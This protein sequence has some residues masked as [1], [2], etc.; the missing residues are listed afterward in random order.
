M[1]YGKKVL[2]LL[3]FDLKW[4]WLLKWICCLS[5]MPTHPGSWLEVSQLL[6][7]SPEPILLLLGGWLPSLDTSSMTSSWE[8]KSAWIKIYR[9][10]HSYR[11]AHCDPRCPQH[12]R[13]H[14]WAICLI[15]TDHQTLHRQIY[16]NGLLVLWSAQLRQY[17]WSII[18]RL[19]IWKKVTF[20]VPLKYYST[21]RHY[22]YCTF[23]I[24]IHFL[25]NILIIIYVATLIDIQGHTWNELHIHKCQHLAVIRRLQSIV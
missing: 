12:T 23:D 7:L 15:L 13:Q 19:E 5:Y 20:Q 18:I 17:N 4:L 11:H 25:N 22:W 10:V 14:P 8:E 6:E 3:P 21:D 9:F 16:C 24:R 2:R 1:V